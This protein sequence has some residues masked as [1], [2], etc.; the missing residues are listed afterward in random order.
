[1]HRF[2]DTAEL[3][4]RL[5]MTLGDWEGHAD[6]AN[7]RAIGTP[8]E[9]Y[10]TRTYHNR[11][12][13]D[14]VSLLVGWGRPEPLLFNHTPRGC[15]PSH[16]YLL[17]GEPRKYVLPNGSAASSL[18]WQATFSKTNQAVPEHLRVFWAW[19]ADG[20]WQ[21]PDSPRRAFAGQSLLYKMY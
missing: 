6:Y 19:T 13:G 1:D 15:Y 18:F 16:G 9:Y 8:G 17:Q 3:V 10:I 21:A 14:T 12:T 5:P 20:N 4:E 11:I 2:A 7:N